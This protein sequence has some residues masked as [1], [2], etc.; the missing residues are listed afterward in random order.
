M[1]GTGPTGPTEPAE[2][3]NATGPTGLA[4][5]NNA[6]GPTGY[7]MMFPSADMGTTPAPMVIDMAE[8]LG[9][10][11]VIQNQEVTDRATLSVLLNETRQILRPQMFTWA[12]AG[13][14]PAYIIQQ[15]TVTSPSVCSDGVV[16]SVYDYVEYLLGQNMGVTIA[17]IQSVCVGV[18]ISYSFQGNTL[19]IHASKV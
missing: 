13:F 10:R 2:V 1:D 9:S 17:A 4:E 8:L 6:T 7:M 16:R 14:P 3:N 11:A 19:R 15:F 18:L 12:A 5:V